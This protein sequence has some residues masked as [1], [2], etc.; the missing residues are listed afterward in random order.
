MC[1]PIPIEKTMTCRE[2]LKALDQPIRNTDTELQKRLGQPFKKNKVYN[3]LL[4]I[5]GQS[6]VERIQTNIG[7]V[8][9]CDRDQK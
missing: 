7:W 5:L 2:L 1:E 3:E 8:E 6:T 9:A 4:K